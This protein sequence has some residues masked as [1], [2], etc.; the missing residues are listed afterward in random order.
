MISTIWRVVFFEREDLPCRRDGSC[1]AIVIGCHFGVSDRVLDVLV[2][3]V[4]LQGPCVVVYL[5]GLDA[6]GVRK[7]PADV[8]V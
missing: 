7:N 5:G 1:P 8:P 4:V 6:A 2:A 3:E